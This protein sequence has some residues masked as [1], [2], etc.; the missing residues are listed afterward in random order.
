M[1]LEKLKIGKQKRGHQEKRVLT[2]QITHAFSYKIS[3]SLYQY[4]RVFFG[5]PA[6]MLYL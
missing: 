3:L 4:A 6:E 5:M 1:V 2:P